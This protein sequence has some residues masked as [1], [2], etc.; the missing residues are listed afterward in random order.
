MNTFQK[1]EE[2]KSLLFWIEQNLLLAK[3]S[4]EFYKKWGDDVF[5]DHAREFIARANR[6]K[7][8]LK[9]L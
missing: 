7:S 8:L 1:I 4:L 9:Q 3:K 5:K 6:F 2:T